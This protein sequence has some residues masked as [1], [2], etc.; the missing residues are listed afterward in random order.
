MVPMSVCLML[1]CIIPNGKP[2]LISP[3]LSTEIIDE[4]LRM[5]VLRRMQTC[6]QSVFWVLDWVHSELSQNQRKLSSLSLHKNPAKDRPEIICF[7]S[8]NCFFQY[9]QSNSFLAKKKLNR[10]GS[11]GGES[12]C[13]LSCESPRLYQQH[14]LVG[15]SF[16]F[17]FLFRLI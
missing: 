4:H 5:I 9:I 8:E 10:L 14:D 13:S 12:F 16:C 15:E 17:L 3:D 6:S 2:V 1:L 11:L 7:A